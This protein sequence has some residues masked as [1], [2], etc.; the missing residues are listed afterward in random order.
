MVF[1]S[2]LFWLPAIASASLMIL[3]DGS[4]GAQPRLVSLWFAAALLAQVFCAVYSAGWVA[5]ILL[6][7]VLALYLLLRM[8]LQ[9]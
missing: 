2:I 1:G 6:Q 8:K 4:L 9:G 5:G 3:L 7:A